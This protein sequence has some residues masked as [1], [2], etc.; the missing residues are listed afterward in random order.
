MKQSDA[1]ELPSARSDYLLFIH[2]SDTIR[3][4]TDCL[5]QHQML[6][7]NSGC[8]WKWFDHDDNSQI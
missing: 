8:I 1:E 2:H 5:L 4:S 7:S 6:T 3:N